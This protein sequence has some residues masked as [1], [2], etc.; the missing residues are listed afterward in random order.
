MPKHAYI[1][2]RNILIFKIMTVDFNVRLCKM[3]YSGLLF[4]FFNG[5]CVWGGGGV[6]LLIVTL[7]IYE[8]DVDDRLESYVMIL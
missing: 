6:P 4:I 8:M 1:G 5:V 7:I 2:S 3:W